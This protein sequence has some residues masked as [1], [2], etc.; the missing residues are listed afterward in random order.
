MSLKSIMIY[1]FI[2]ALSATVVVMIMP[3]LIPILHDLK[4]GQIVRDDGPKEHL[5]KMGTPTMGGLAFIFSAVIFSLMYAHIDD[6]I[7]MLILVTVGFGAVGFIDDYIKID[8][9]SKD[10][11]Y[12]GQK[13]LGLAIVAAVFVMYIRRMDMDTRIVIPFLSNVRVNLYY[14]YIPFAVLVL[15]STTNAVNL[16][17]GLDGLAAGIGVIV[18]LFFAFVAMMTK[19]CMYIGFFCFAV[20]GALLGFLVFNKNPAKIFM[21][22]TGSLALGGAIA[23]VALMLKNPLVLII[24][25]GVCVME[26]LSV[27]I[28]VASFKITGK[29]VF[30]MAPLH[31]HFELCGMKETTVVRMFWLVSVLLCIVGY[32]SMI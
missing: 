11:L 24:V 22:D 12:P 32:F 19:D 4:F 26:A 23:G 25:C 16:T 5:K 13:M 2:M 27:I 29:R 17:D 30:K 31:H 21:G 18:M 10:G 28:Q 6:R 7:L 3:I 9:K 20:V 1:L 15:L 8:K 14:F